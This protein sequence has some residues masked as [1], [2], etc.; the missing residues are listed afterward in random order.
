MK[1]KRGANI[2]KFIHKKFKIMVTSR[3]IVCCKYVKKNREAA[4][5]IAADALNSIV[6]L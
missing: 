4:M 6:N 3:I 2:S 5:K 1:Q